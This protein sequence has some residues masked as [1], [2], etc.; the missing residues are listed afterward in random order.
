L[1]NMTGIVLLK[2]PNKALLRGRLVQKGSCVAAALSVTLDCV[3][4][5]SDFIVNKNTFQSL[6]KTA[7]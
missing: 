2:K 3:L 6:T 5:K 1:V 4:P 7:C